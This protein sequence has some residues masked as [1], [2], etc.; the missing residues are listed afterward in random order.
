[1]KAAGLTR[2]LAKADLGTSKGTPV[3]RLG[4]LV[5][6]DDSTSI[7]SSRKRAAHG[8]VRV[9]PQL[10]RK[11]GCAKSLDGRREAANRGG[12]HAG[13]GFRRECQSDLSASRFFCMKKCGTATRAQYRRLASASLLVEDVGCAGSVGGLWWPYDFGLRCRPPVLRRRMFSPKD[14]TDDRNE[15]QLDERPASRIVPPVSPPMPIRL[16]SGF[17]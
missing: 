4:L 8:N 1:M 13:F 11:H 5:R 14:H 3:I 2:G 17:S 12:G 10:F 9:G 7:G 15:D 6:L 16:E